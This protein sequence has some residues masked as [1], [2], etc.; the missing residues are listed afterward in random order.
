MATILADQKSQS[1]KMLLL[2]LSD[3]HVKNST[4]PVLQRSEAIVAAIKNLDYEIDAAVIL[5]SGDLAFSG[6]QSQYNAVWDFIERV[7]TSLQA[8]LATQSAR[9]DVHVRTLAIPGNHDCDFSAPK[10]AREMLLKSVLSEGSDAIDSSVVEQCTEVEN[11]FFENLTRSSEGMGNP[12]SSFDARLA[13]E[14]CVPV[15]QRTVRFV[16]FNTAWMSQRHEEQGDLFFPAAAV[17]NGRGD[18]DLVIATFHHPYNW[19]ESNAARPFRKKVEAL[20]DIVLTGHEHDATVRSQMMATGEANLYIEGGAL[21]NSDDPS[22]SIFNVFVLDVENRKQKTARF[23]WNGSR[24]VRTGGTNT[25]GDAFGLVWEELQITKLR[26]QAQYELSES[27]NARLDDIGVNLVHR[28]RGELHLADIFIFPDLEE[29]V[30][31]VGRNTHYIRGGNVP[32]LLGDSAHLMLV[33]ESQAG[34]TTLAKAVFR[35]M[36]RAGY[37]PIWLEAT[38]STLRDDRLHGQM[39]KLFVEQYASATEEAYRQ[40]DRAQRAVI[41][42][43]FHRLPSGAKARRS[44]IRQ[45]VTFAGRVILFADTLTSE[46]NDLFHPEAIVELD[47]TFSVYR[48]APF[49]HVRREEL[50]DRWLQLDNSIDERGVTFADQRRSITQVLDALIGR[51][52]LPPYPVYILSVLQSNEAI[53][54]VDT[55]ISTYGAYY[56]LYI[57]TALAR[58]K[59]PVQ[60]EMTHSYLA[61][62]AYRLFETE[63]SE[64]EREDVTRLHH[65][66]EQ[67]FEIGLDFRS[68]QADLTACGILIVTN[69]IVKF[70]Y[71]YIYYYFVASWIRDHIS[72]DPVRKVIARLS[73]SVYIEEH[74]NI[75][76]FLAHL[77][78]DPLI[79]EKLL[80]AARS[81]YPNTKPA[82][83]DND[84]DFL[85]ALRPGERR[86]EYRE[87]DVNADRK[88]R[89]EALDE[90]EALLDEGDIMPEMSSSDPSKDMLDPLVTLTAAVK[91][92]EILGQVLKNFPGSLDGDVKMEIAQGC[93]ALGL[94]ALNE[95]YDDFR[96]NNT[97]ILDDVII[98]L[99]QQSPG[100][101]SDHAKL[102]AYNIVVALA[103]AIGLTLVR[104]IASAVGSKELS[105]TYKRVLNQDPTPAHQLIDTS[106]TL[107]HTPDFP[108]NSVR[109]LARELKNNVFALAILSYCV[110]YHFHVFPVDRIIKQRVC[111]ELG[112]T[113]APVIGA[114]EN[115]KLLSKGSRGGSHDSNVTS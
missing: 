93:Y 86:V 100:L 56:E 27:M 94:R 105:Q 22:E 59:M 83:L 110:I 89:L 65:E 71:K 97:E 55:R 113:Y 8:N 92:I 88:Q 24:Y 95:I 96:E 43:N 84:M 76:L 4:D 36:R 6:Q 31:P 45:L 25:D 68:I 115:R 16:C 87:T 33:G 30:Y 42:D 79:V 106:I 29:I 15:G 14:C 44:F 37:V 49:G 26:G 91:T 101:G 80:E 21:Q 64:I 108:E 72:T 18:N 48:I 77:S 85:L 82:R 54:P 114:N 50:V 19:I 60:A 23:S 13:Y 98:T 107:D 52:W 81:Y 1:G 66:F 51:N 112:I 109:R 78:K 28:S 34:K 5:I 40:L 11:C 2:Q 39:I 20:A 3:I 35:Q 103:E 90:Q 12:L 10:K 58:K 102:R 32:Q 46:L 111:R 74:A 61:F 73:R 99:Q 9:R 69:T 70:K 41:V 75:L 7:Q 47:T 38:A 53:N 57:R 104:A 62:L 63:Q 17:P 67:R